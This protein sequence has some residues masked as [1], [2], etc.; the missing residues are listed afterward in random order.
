MSSSRSRAELIVALAAALFGVLTVVA[1]GRVLLGGDPGYVVYRPLLVFN[2]V[3]GVAYVGVA[4]LAWRGHRA[5]VIGASVVA[6]SNLL[7]LVILGWLFATGAAVATESL[8]AMA[9]RAIAWVV[10]VAVLARRRPTSHPG[11]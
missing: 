1:G 7:V 3:M 8:G 9:F 6:A 5:A 4:L 2:T 10:L 11:R